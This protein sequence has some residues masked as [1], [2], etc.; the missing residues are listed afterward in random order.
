[1]RRFTTKMLSVSLMAA[2]T[3]S[4]GISGIAM[5]EEEGEKEFSIFAGMSTMSNDYSE[6]TLIK[7][8]NEE[9]GVNINWT[10]V[11]GDALTEKKNLI[12][13]TGVDLPDAV[14]GIGLS[15]YELITYG[16]NGL[17]VPIEDYITEDIMPNLCSVVE[18]RPG[19][20]ASCTMPDGHIYSLP[21]I[22]EMGIEAQNGEVYYIGAIPQFTAINTDWLEAVGME[23]PKTVDELHD[24]LVAFRDQDVN[25]NGDPT[26]EIPLSF[27][28]GNWCAGM[29]TLFAPFG[30]T[31]YN[32]QHRAVTAD[33][34]V[35]FQATSEAYKNAIAYYHQ[36]YEEGLIDIEVFSQEASQYIAKGASEDPRLGV[37]VWWEIPEVVGYDR[38]ESYAYLPILTD[39]EG[40]SNV[41]LNEMGTTGH[42]KFAVTRNCKD[43]A[44]L[45]NW[46]DKFY[47]PYNSMQAI[48]GPIGEFFAEEPDENG[49]YVTRE[50]AEGESEGELKGKLEIYA[51]TRQLFDDFGTYYYMEDR[52]QQRLEDLRDFWFPSVKD[53]TYYPS[54]T[55]TLEETETINEYISDIQDYVSE[56]GANWLKNGG[57]EDE[58]DDYCETLNDIG[59]QEVVDCWQS[60]YDRYMEK[61][62]E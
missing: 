8:I 11:A 50:L 20:L 35:Y 16:G 58:W 5:A 9:T 28:W 21:G 36:W 57:I 7:Q 40:N 17:F 34:E 25:G 29:T 47:D 56:C 10:C 27:M 44:A 59:L 41:N 52:A 62:E 15:D 55:Y 4:M 39:T 1:M 23:M 6:K 49:V 14:M 3:A 2:L 54:V 24:V 26:D 18:Q 19:L 61:V 22:S 32:D 60:A 42:D 43:I 38:A 31:D 33:G 30:C 45:L 46:V 13:N 37:F 12:L 53:F 51:P 48:Y